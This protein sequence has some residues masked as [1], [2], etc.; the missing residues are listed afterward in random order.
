MSGKLLKSVNRSFEDFSIRDKRKIRQELNL[1]NI[2]SVIKF[3]RDAG[4]NLGKKI[5]TQQKRAFNYARDKYNDIVEEKNKVVLEER[6]EKKKTDTFKKSFI[7]DLTN[8]NSRVVRNPSREKMSMLLGIM[9]DKFLDSG[10]RYNMS[11]GN[12]HYALNDA[13]V[14]RLMDDL[15]EIWFESIAEGEGSDIEIIDII[16]DIKSIKFYEYEKKK[17]YNL[18]P[19]FFK[20]SHNIKGLDLTELQIY[21]DFKAEYYTEN[22][23]IH[24][25]I[26]E[27]NEK[28]INDCKLII[29]SK[30]TRVKDIKTIAEKHNLYI[31]VRV[32]DKH[33][34][35]YNKQGSTRID[36]GILD[37]HYFKIKKIPVNSFALKNYFDICDKED[38]NK[39]YKKRKGHY[40][41]REN[42]IDSY[43]VVKILL[44]NKDTHLRKIVKCDELY[45]TEYFDK[46]TDIENLDYHYNVEYDID[47]DKWIEEG[48]L[49]LN[50]YKYKVCEYRP[51]KYTKKG[52]GIPYHNVFFDFETDPHTKPHTPFLVRCCF[53][54]KN[55]SV[56]HKGFYGKDCGLEM[57]RFLGSYFRQQPLKLI[58]HNLG[59]D[60]NFIAGYVANL[61]L[62]ESGSMCKGG[63]GVF[64]LDKNRKVH[65]KF[66]DSYAL[67]PTKLSKFKDMFGIETEKEFIP[68]NLLTRTNIK[69][70][71]ISFSKVKEGV[72]KQ[73]KSNCIG[74]NPPK[75]MIDSN[76][77]LMMDNGKKWGCI[78]NNKFDIVEY[79]DKYCYYDCK[80]LKEGYEKFCEMINEVCKM[81]ADAYMTI[82]QLA[83]DYL[84]KEKCYTGVYM[85]NGVVREFI[86]LCMVGGRTMCAENKKQYETGSIDDYDACSLYPSAMERLGGFLLGVPK[87]IQNKSYDFIKDKD[88]YFVEIKIKQIPKHYRFPLISYKNGEGV[89]IFSDKVED[90]NNNSVYV[91]KASLEDLIKFYEDNNSP[92]DFKFEIIKGYYYDEGRNMKLKPV[93]QHLYNTRLEMKALG[94]PIQNIYKLLMNSS[95]GKSL[96]KPIDNEIHYIYTKEKADKFIV[97]NYTRHIETDELTFNNMWRVKVSKPIIDHFNNAH[98]G[99][100]VLSMSKRIMNEVMCLAED[101]GIKIFYQD[102]DSMHL[103]TEDVPKLEN[104][105]KEIYNRDLNGKNMGQFHTDFDS[106][107]L[108]GEIYSK[109]F[110]ALGKKCYL[111]VL[112]DDTGK[113]DYHIR[114]KGVSG[115]SVKHHAD[116]DYDNIKHLYERL[117]KGDAIPFDLCCNHQKVC[118]EKQSNFTI[119]SKDNFWRVICFDN[120][121]ERKKMKIE[122][123]QKLLKE[124]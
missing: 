25:L 117:H 1:K 84:K 6:R 63:A 114:M 15:D 29:K 90:Y 50:E 49:K 102:T 52:E 73:T 31:C 10:K 66:Q 44:Q 17:S 67:I 11:S 81:D 119:Q 98:C 100:E 28:I 116:K 9:K 3:A 4:V 34:R 124:K 107:I 39:I 30:E 106:K 112:T 87:V 86:Q 62:I 118:F 60:I 12:K 14:S 13:T 83:D 103:P 45:K 123:E 70:R 65:L 33:Y 115:D 122:T 64:Y 27:V 16:K 51:S 48:N 55:G 94:N 43:N 110:I 18:K 47:K 104:K 26:G 76:Y 19:K 53:A 21:E 71:F 74:Y 57:L 72:I 82:A 121:S 120:D 7:R 96:L 46:I 93:I 36:I 22:C 78:Q 92:R 108:K 23:F 61:E 37:D 85:V 97:N 88:G 38:W 54:T 2:K 91:D 68:Y 95:Y 56:R 101:I 99:V 41:R 75:S 105:F 42:F 24:S 80:V 35:H 79:C 40:E 59:Y 32:D 8:K 109:C 89:R 113:E 5:K 69:K 58:A 111:D 77:N 20:Y